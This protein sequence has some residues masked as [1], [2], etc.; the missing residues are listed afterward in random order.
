MIFIALQLHVGVLNI[1]GSD[2]IV[3]PPQMSAKHWFVLVCV[4]ALW[5]R[6]FLLVHPYNIVTQDGGAEF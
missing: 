6:D 3:V 2:G 5:R 1:L 4:M